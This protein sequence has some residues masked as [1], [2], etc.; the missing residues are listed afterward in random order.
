ML[1]FLNRDARAHGLSPGQIRANHYAQPTTGVSM[2]AADADELTDRCAAIALALA[3]H[4]VFTHLTSARLRD[5]WLPR[6]TGEPV[7]ACTDG[8]AAHHDR[9]G[10]YVRRCT[11]PD[12]HRTHLRGVPVASPEWTIVEL[13]EHLRLVDLVVAIDCAL[14]RG[15]TTVDRVRATMRRGR[16]GVKVLRRALDLVDGRSESPWETVLRLAHTLSGIAVEPQ[17][18]LRDETT[19]EIIWSLDLLIHRTR[20]AAEFDG[21]VHRTAEVH[22]RD[23]RRDRLLNRHGIERYAHGARDLL[24]DPAQVVRD[25]EDALGQPHLPGR[26]AVWLDEFAQSAFTP[27]GHAAL[28]HRIERFARD[29]SPRSRAPRVAHE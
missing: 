13:A 29:T 14:H 21:G 23:M 10:V 22:Q 9:R 20:R 3:G 5:W 24:D 1:P 25:A 6:I 19:G 15:E 26:A 18:Q 12:D 7:I 8:E 2:L 28:R 11:L 16:R 4:A 27:R 17:H